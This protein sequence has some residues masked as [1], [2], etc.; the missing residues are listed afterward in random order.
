MMGQKIK[1]ITN[2]IVKVPKRNVS[3]KRLS[4]DCNRYLIIT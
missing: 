1:V 4:V 2:Q 3:T